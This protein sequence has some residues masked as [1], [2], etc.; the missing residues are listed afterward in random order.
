MK[1]K[2]HKSSDGGATWT[3]VDF[4]N[5]FP[6]WDN[7]LIDMESIPFKPRESRFTFISSASSNDGT[8]DAQIWVSLDDGAS[9][10]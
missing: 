3:H 8:K 5:L 2:F 7:Y 6:N 4:F 1:K 10:T 9:W